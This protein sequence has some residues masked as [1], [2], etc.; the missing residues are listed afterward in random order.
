MHDGDVREEPPEAGGGTLGVLAL[1]AAAF[2]LA[3]TAIVP[4][5]TD[6]T[7]ALNTSTANVSWVLSGYLVSAAIFT[8]I[9]GRLGDMF[10]KRRMLIVSLLFFAGGSV[11][12]AL[13]GTIWLLVAARV[14]QGVSGGIFPLC[15][16]IISDTFP[17]DRRP[18]ALGLISAIAGIGAGGGLLM[19]GLLIDHASWQWI[20][21]AGAIM[22]GGAALGTLRVPASGRRTPGR[23]DVPGA[24]L[25]AAGLAALLL[26]LTK[27]ATWGWGDAR[28]LGLVAAGLLVL[29]LFGLYERRA[30]EPLVNMSVFGRPA[31][32]A[33]N[34]TTMLV[35]T[36]MFGAFVLIP[37]IAQT[38]KSSGYGFGVD[39]TGAGLLLLPAC[40][41]MLVAGPLSGKL[42][43]RF[44]PKVPLVA[45]VLVAA[46]GL[47][48]LA[49]AHGSRAVVTLLSMVVFTGIGL[50]MAAIPNLIVRAVP[51]EMTGQATGVNAL[52][53][54]I[55]SSLG[56]QVVATLLAASVTATHPI[57][58]DHAF[59]Q[60]F[61]LGA[62]AALLA[63][64]AASLVP[65]S[66]R[67]AAEPLSPADSAA[68][69]VPYD[70]GTRT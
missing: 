23:I 51:P 7:R 62:G 59:T 41:M 43:I 4:G 61:W 57:P 40:L 29:V 38:P 10:G 50:S 64:V 45:G 5:L 16:G 13:S 15:F 17:G 60:A 27:T 55:G 31:V 58:T 42:T 9:M 46:L 2:A 18:G 32:L 52:V 11:L 53:R 66:R 12:A 21:W 36:G 6:L 39:A 1:A 49:P 65:R 19:G 68:S 33:T 63:A 22:A 37:Q 14:V 44:S 67:S 20:F 24:L 26:A 56:S 34:L 69:T 54:S 3:Q 35:G 70:Q 30:A 28:T 25:L 48:A 47:T 8:P